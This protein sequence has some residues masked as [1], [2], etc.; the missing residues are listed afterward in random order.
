ME[1]YVSPCVTAKK[2][3]VIMVMVVEK[4]RL[5]IKVFLLLQDTDDKLLEIQYFLPKK[6]RNA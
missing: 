1:S 2:W 6:L 5:L 4:V 3:I